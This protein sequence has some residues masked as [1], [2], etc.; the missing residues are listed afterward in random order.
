ME[1]DIWI[2]KIHVVED[3]H[4][5]EVHDAIFVV[6]N[7]HNEKNSYGMGDSNTCFLNVASQQ[8][9]HH[10]LSL[11]VPVSNY[12]LFNGYDLIGATQSGQLAILSSTDWNSF[13]PSETIWQKCCQCW[14]QHT[15]ATNADELLRII[16]V[17]LLPWMKSHWIPVP[18]KESCNTSDSLSAVRFLPDPIPSLRTAWVC[19]YWYHLVCTRQLVLQPTAHSLQLFSRHGLSCVWMISGS[20]EAYLTTFSAANSLVC[21]RQVSQPCQTI[22]RPLSQQ[23]LHQQGGKESK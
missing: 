1:F 23:V 18:K 3:W 4:H 20:A 17:Q 15:P 13:Q 8:H 11:T 7:A 10:E 21:L 2:I 16:V 22:W 14:G 12:F 5:L 9:I 19:L 6:W